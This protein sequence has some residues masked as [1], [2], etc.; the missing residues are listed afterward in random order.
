MQWETKR[1]T[2]KHHHSSAFPRLNLS[3][4]LLTLP[5]LSNAEG[6]GMGL[7]VSPLQF[8]SATPSSTHFSSLPAWVVQEN[9][10]CCGLSTGCRDDLFLHGTPPPPSLTLAFPLLFLTVSPTCLLLL[11][12]SSIFCPFLN[13]LSLRHHDLG[14][15]VQLYPLVGPLELARTGCVQHHLFSHR[16]PL[17]SPH[18]PYVDTCTK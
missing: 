5:P 17:Q 13:M 16:P 11:C 3:P 2:L 12:P 8:L 7:A 10:L 18:C 6:W 1:H 4:S 9:L 14:W 15:W